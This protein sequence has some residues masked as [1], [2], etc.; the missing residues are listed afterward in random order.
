[1]YRSIVKP[2]FDFVLAVILFALLFPFFILITILLALD[3]GKPF[4]R[5]KRIGEG[6]NRV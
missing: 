3:V 1:M 6:I 4:F 5:Q 2:V